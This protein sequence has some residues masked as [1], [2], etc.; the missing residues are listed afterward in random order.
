[1]FKE[2]SIQNYYFANKDS[3]KNG[4][5]KCLGEN[6]RVLAGKISYINEY[7]KEKLNIGILIVISIVLTFSQFC[8]IGISFGTL[9][10]HDTNCLMTLYITRTFICT[11]N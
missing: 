4:A 8:I 3:V 2:N 1:M 9:A 6:P 5:E 7:Q 11:C 10:F